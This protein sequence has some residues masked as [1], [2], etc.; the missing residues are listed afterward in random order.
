MVWSLKAKAITMYTNIICISYLTIE[1]E[2]SLIKTR[3][4]NKSILMD[5]GYTYLKHNIYVLT[6]SLFHKKKNK[7]NICN[8]FE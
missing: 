6:N 7:K 3:F 8:I 4:H 2:M 1:R 5:A